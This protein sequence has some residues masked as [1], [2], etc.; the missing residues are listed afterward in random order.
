M[1]R[2]KILKSFVGSQDGLANSDFTEGEEA[3][4]SDY[5]MGCID[6]SW[7]EEIGEVEN[8]SEDQDEPYRDHE[9][10]L[11]NKAIITEGK[12]GGKK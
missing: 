10:D 9:A 5:L 8:A 1:N 12:K 7:V 6:K 11:S 3:L 2:V 4:L